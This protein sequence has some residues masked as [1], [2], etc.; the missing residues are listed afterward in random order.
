M[1]PTNS[2][3]WNIHFCF[4]DNRSSWR[5]LLTFCS[6]L[7][8]STRKTFKNHSVSYMINHRL[9]T[10]KILFYLIPLTNNAYL[11][12]IELWRNNFNSKVTLFISRHCL[13]TNKALPNQIILN[14]HHSV[15]LNPKVID[16]LVFLVDSYGHKISL[17]FLNY[18]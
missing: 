11:N 10:C 5:Y 2:F 13:I 15:S 14:L 1:K 8:V 18:L 12:V 16:K 6:P 9:F 17:F 7:T 4:N 3:I